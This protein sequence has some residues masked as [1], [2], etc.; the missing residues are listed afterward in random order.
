M[1]KDKKPGL[2]KQYTQDNIKMEKNTAKVNLCGLMTVP[3]KAIS[4]KIIFM[5]LENIN[6]KMVD[7]T[8]V[9]G[10][11]TKC[12]VKG[13]LHGLTEEN[14]LETMQKIAKKDL[15]CLHLKTAGFIKVNG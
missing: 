12:K 3:L 7:P 6:G 14:M 13:P 10:K 1:V 5:V 2:T 15:V 8:K 9:N 11:I 4:F